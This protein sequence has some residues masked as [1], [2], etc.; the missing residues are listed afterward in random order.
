LVSRSKRKSDERIVF[1]EPRKNIP[2]RLIWVWSNPVVASVSTIY[3][4]IFSANGSICTHRCLR[5]PKPLRLWPSPNSLSDIAGIKYNSLIPS[6]KCVFWLF[7]NASI[8]SGSRGYG[9]VTS[10]LECMRNRNS[11]IDAHIEPSALHHLHLRPTSLKHLNSSFANTRKRGLKN[12]A[13]VVGVDWPFGMMQCCTALGRGTGLSRPVTIQQ[14][15]K[16]TATCLR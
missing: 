13:D 12:R 11:K 1:N 8:S 6:L 2:S 10:E 5:S 3:M 7:N 4:S 16:S 14:V 15:G 9:T